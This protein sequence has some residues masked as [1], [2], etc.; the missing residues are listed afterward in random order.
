[1]RRTSL[2]G[3]SKKDSAY[4][5]N[6]QLFNKR[7]LRYGSNVY[8]WNPRFASMVDSFLSGDPVHNLSKNSSNIL[9]KFIAYADS[10]LSS[11]DPDYDVIEQYNT[12]LATL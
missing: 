4:S 9:D 6:E 10:T 1:M 8:T 11:A 5:G 3:T 2:L 12:H 7:S